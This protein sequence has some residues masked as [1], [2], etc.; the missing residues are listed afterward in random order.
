MIGKGGNIRHGLGSPR[1]RLSWDLWQE[2]YCG[3]FCGLTPL[4]DEGPLLAAG[5]TIT[6]LEGRMGEGSGQHAIV[7]TMVHK[8]PILQ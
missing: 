5:V 6:E 4:R 8:V 3:V 2:V 1:S 7:P